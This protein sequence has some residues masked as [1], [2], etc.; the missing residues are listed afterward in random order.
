MTYGNRY[1]GSGTVNPWR[2]LDG[3]R[4]ARKRKAKPKRRK[5]RSPERIAELEKKNRKIA[6]KINNRR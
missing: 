6:A 2:A 3:E 5:R 1:P 4:P